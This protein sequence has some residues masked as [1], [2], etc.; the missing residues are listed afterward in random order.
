MHTVLWCLSYCMCISVIASSAYIP[1]IIS[2][3]RRLHSVLQ[4]ITC[5]MIDAVADSSTLDMAQALTETPQWL[6]KVQVGIY[7]VHTYCFYLNKTCTVHQMYVVI[8]Y[9]YIFRLDVLPESF[10]WLWRKSEVTISKASLRRK[11]IWFPHR[12]SFTSR[13][14]T[15]CSFG[16]LIITYRVFHIIFFKCNS[17]QA[18]EREGFARLCVSGL[19]WQD[20]NSQ[21]ELLA[22]SCPI[23]PCTHPKSSALPCKGIHSE[24]ILVT[25]EGVNWHEVLHQHWLL[26]TDSLCF[27]HCGAWTLLFQNV[28]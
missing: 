11:W 13:K 18:F 1:H 16:H 7:W 3:D 12:Y 24:Y 25:N 19:H 9:I 21:P 14:Q 26:W 22:S 6:S 20:G 28:M 10:S 17:F 8:I 4:G 27:K 15:A 5:K 2:W 23:P